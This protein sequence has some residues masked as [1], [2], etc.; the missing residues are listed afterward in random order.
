MMG[1]LMELP[2][3][4]SHRVSKSFSRGEAELQMG[5]LMWTRPGNFSLRPSM[6]S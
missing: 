6:T 4:V 3:R 2:T 1:V 5:I